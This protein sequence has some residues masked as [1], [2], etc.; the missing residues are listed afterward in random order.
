MKWYADNSELNGDKESEI[1]DIF[2][3]GGIVV[4]ESMEKSLQLAVE[5]IKKEYGFS[6]SPIKW[7]MRDLKK[8]YV[9]HGILYVYENLIQ[10]S[11]I[12][13]EA[14]FEELVKHEVTIIVACIESYSPKRG[15]IKL[16]KEEL[17]S[18]AFGNGLMRFGLH[19]KDHSPESAYVLLDW[20]DKGNSKPFDIEYA[21][22]Y[23]FG[24]TPGQRITYKCGALNHLGFSDSIYYTNAHYST[25]LQV[26]DMVVGSSREFIECCLGKKPPGQGVKCLKIVKSIIR[27]APDKIL[28]RGIIVSTGNTELRNKVENG[29]VE[30][31]K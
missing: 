29:I 7:N 25:L 27:G 19:V 3:F 28:G 8:L 11:E 1:T 15:K 2:L 6:H 5:E 4:H 26:A 24:K 10:S 9:R 13:R 12:W 23:N 22:A 21:N 14:I 30:L 20:P 31:L 17:A 16:R 18:H